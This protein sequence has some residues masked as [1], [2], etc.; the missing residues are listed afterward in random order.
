VDF[1]L[2]PDAAEIR[3]LVRR[4]GQERFRPA[5]FERRHDFAPPEENLRLLAELGILGMC[6]PQEYGGAGR[7]ELD[8]VLAMEELAHAC[9]VTAAYTILTLTGPAS[10]IAKLGSDE[11]K[12]RYL[13]ALCDGT[14]R[15]AISMTEPEAGSAVTDMKTRAEI[16]RDSCVIN[17]QKIFC[18]GAPHSHYFLVYVRFGPGVR[19]IGAVLVNRDTP[20]FTLSTPHR[21]IS[22]ETWCELFFDDATIPVEDVV[23]TGDAF[24]QLMAGFSYER[25]GAGAFAIGVAQIAMDLALE[26]VEDRRQFGRRLGDFQ[27]IQAKLADM[28]IALE[29]ARLLIYRSIVRGQDGFPNRLDSSAAKIAA[30]DAASMVTNAA[31]QMHGGSGMSQ[32]LP[33]EWLYRVVRCYEVAGGTSDVLRIGMAGELL[34]RRIDQRPPAVEPVKTGS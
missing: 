1:E 32:E 20:G 23:V 4:V 2:S 3:D 16:R 6:L 11:Q 31:M 7:S 22:G 8:A 12:A 15:F 13:P 21:H 14:K 34:G 24:R 27:L 33:L 28:Y 25:C 10:V 30:T 18:S 5:A 26:Y 9:P 19:G 17:G 29:S